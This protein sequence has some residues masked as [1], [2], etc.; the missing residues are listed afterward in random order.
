MYHLNYKCQIV[1]LAP[2][3]LAVLQCDQIGRFI[4]LRATFQRLWQQLFCPNCPHFRQF[5]WRCPNLSFLVESFLGNFYRHW[6]LFTGHTGLIIDVFGS[7]RFETLESKTVENKRLIIHTFFL[8]RSSCRKMFAEKSCFLFPKK[9][10]VIFYV[11][12]NRTKRR[13]ALCQFQFLNGSS[14]LTI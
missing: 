8:P 5:L 10:S 6:R 9:F 2:L 4:A 13:F 11:K 1:H 14:Q 7:P 12:R 3:N